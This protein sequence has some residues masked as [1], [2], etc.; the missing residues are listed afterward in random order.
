MLVLGFLGCRGRH[1]KKRRVDWSLHG[2]AL[3]RGG[4]RCCRLPL[5]LAG[6]TK[7]L[8]GQTHPSYNGRALRRTSRVW[9]FWMGG[10]SLD[11][12][13]VGEKSLGGLRTNGG[14]GRDMC[15]AVC[16]STG[17]DVCVCPVVLCFP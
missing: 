2:W 6:P 13:S 14:C 9:I 15:Q 4:S 12:W 5:Q 7:V 16:W 8:R 3:G 10:G 1:K 17:Q 11:K